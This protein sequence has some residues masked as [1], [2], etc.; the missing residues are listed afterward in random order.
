MEFKQ[1]NLL[2][3]IFIMVMFYIPV[4]AQT[5]S[6]LVKD[7]F[8]M[9]LEDLLNIEITTASKYE[10]TI[11]EAPSS[12]TII[13]SNEIRDFGYNTLNEALNSQKGF[14]SS[15]D[16][17]YSYIGNRGFG[18]PSEYN[19][20][21][22]LL[23]N[24]HTLNENVYGSALL[25]SDL[26]LNLDIIDRIEIVRG[27][28]SSMYG[29]GAMLNVINIITKKGADLDGLNI[30]TS[31]GSYNKKEISAYWGKTTGKGTD[32]VISGI[33][34]NTT[35]PD[36]YFEELDSPET[37]NGI[38][39]GLDWEKL[40]GFYSEISAKNFT[41][42][43]SL[44]NRAKGIPT[45]AWE[46]DLVNISKSL[47]IRYFVD[48]QYKK[49]FNENFSIVFRSY[50]DGY[51]YDG[52]YSNGSYKLFDKSI[53]KWGGSELQFVYNNNHRNLFSGGIEF[54]Y[55]THASYKEW[56]ADDV[57]SSINFPF[58]EFS[59]YV[60]DEYKV[61]PNLRMTAGLRFD[62]NSFGT[63]SLAPRFAAVYNIAKTS[64]FK[65]LYSEAHRTPNFYE[66]K[67]E[68]MDYQ[69]INSSIKPERIQTKEFVWEYQPKNNIYTSLSLYHYKMKELIDLTIDDNDGLTFF[70]NIGKVT[71]RGVEFEIKYNPKK[72][73]TLFLNS[74][75]QK[76]VNT[77]TGDELTNSPRFL[78]KGGWAQSIAGMFT[79]SPEC[80]YETKRTTIYKT[81]TNPFFLTNVSLTS[82]T[83][84]K[85]IRVNLK[86]RNIFNQEYSYPGGFE[87]VQKTIIQDGRNFS[88]GVSV[89][90]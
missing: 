74:T 46:T 37:N 86:I 28:G 15:Y 11:F 58:S 14:Y 33:A 19:N 82:K 8:D 45:G 39:T 78:L 52:T 41:L 79:F 40:Y 27:P 73:T 7:L 77:D 5:D 90:M 47:D 85:Y 68:S 1:K 51:K 49:D 87:H 63:N 83:I 71:G 81:S 9:S 17:N 23:L 84:F 55:N 18:R 75:L 64:T 61:L 29:S 13:T 62:Y 12:V 22:R 6:V 4:S 57:Y 54:K 36:L 30:K 24:G 80:F 34:G 88:I 20:R 3:V 53:G 25:G 48:L 89:Q 70:Q 72:E 35:G 38:S 44:S 2:L 65:L 59:T 32:I 26:S 43:A 16:R 56:D 42:K 76:S 67:Y 21:S 10:Q 60:Q 50:Y 31:L 69:K 66:S